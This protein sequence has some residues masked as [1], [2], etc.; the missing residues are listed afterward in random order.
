MGLERAL[1]PVMVDLAGLELEPDEREILSH[2]LVGGVILFAR[3]YAAPDQLRGLTRSIREVR[4]PPLLV[5]VDH[6]GGRVQRFLEGFTRLPPMRTVGRVHDRNAALAGNLA[7]AIGIVLAAELA[8][9]GIDFSFAPVLDVDFGSSSV[10]GDRA[11]HSDPRVVATLAE[12]LV[13]GMARIGMAAVGKHFPGHGYVRADS[14][15]EVPV[16]ERD[17]AAIE[18]SDLVPYRALIRR[19]L[20]GVMP[21]HVI[22]PQ[23][24]ARPAGFSPVWLRDILRSRLGFDGVIFSDDL[25]MAGAA[26]AGGIVER[27]RAALEAGCDIVLVCNARAAAE[28]LLDELGPASL[29]ASRAARMRGPRALAPGR[30]PDYRTALA[31]VTRGRDTGVLA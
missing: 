21:A 16:D 24:D 4:D 6:E 25:S 19:G 11:L 13:D 10:I 14:H 29:D 23:V 1:G 22:Y 28:Q 26:V 17:L 27:G 12:A 5:A 8:A 15:H 31:E 3:N 30:L 20:A 9:H 18:A 7:G 2:P